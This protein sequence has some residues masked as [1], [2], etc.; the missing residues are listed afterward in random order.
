MQQLPAFVLTSAVLTDG[1]I[2][3]LGVQGQDETHLRIDQ[4]N[5]Y[6]G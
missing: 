3:L 1:E 6:L 4:L 2:Q 5:L